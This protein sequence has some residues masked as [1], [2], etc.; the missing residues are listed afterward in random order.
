M[1]ALI[2]YTTP[3]FNKLKMKVRTTLFVNTVIKNIDGKSANDKEVR[4][5]S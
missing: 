3:K 2:K 1:D 4:E 5:Y